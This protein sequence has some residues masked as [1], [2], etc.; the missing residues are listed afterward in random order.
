MVER[1]LSARLDALAELVTIGRLREGQEQARHGQGQDLASRGADGFSK[2][3]LD[4]SEALLRRTG[5]RL[6]LSANHTAV[7]LAGGTGSGKSTLFN[8]LSG[9]SFSP[10]GVTRPTTRHAHACVWGMQ[11]AAPLLDW[12][13]V[14]RRH[15]YARASALDSGEAAL[16]GLLLLDLPDHDSVDTASMAA[17]DR[18][19]KLAALLVWVL[20]P[21]TD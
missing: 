18:L 5:E 13:G 20:G 2:S 11:G 1:N 14:Q 15:R 7:A 3:L 4:N 6:R 9:A 16:D 17:V 8:A 21:H 12:L 19:S 10:P